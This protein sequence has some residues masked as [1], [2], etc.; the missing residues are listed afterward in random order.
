MR[1][2][3]SRKAE[4]IGV[5]WAP[6]HLQPSP[7]FGATKARL[8]PLRRDSPRM[9]A[10][11]GRELENADDNVCFACGPSNPLGLR[12]RFFD[13]GA[14]TRSRLTLDER[15]AGDA[16]HVLHGVLY[17]AMDDAVWWCA[18]ARWGELPTDADPDAPRVAA[19]PGVVRTERPF[20][21]E[22]RREGYG[23]VATFDA[24]AVQD[25]VVRARLSW[26]AR[27]R[28]RDEIEAALADPALAPSLRPIYEAALARRA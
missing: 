1:S 25:G 27:R 28:T 6:G 24:V 23:D 16:R 11:A 15:Y 3:T 20:V 17:A 22:A 9:D 12:M 4:A 18:W 21:V 13:D 19:F 26:K 10:L 5:A 8:F 7:G 2:T 14:V